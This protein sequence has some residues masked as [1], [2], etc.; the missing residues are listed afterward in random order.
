MKINERKQGVIMANEMEDINVLGA[1]E[2]AKADSLSD[3]EFGASANESTG[4]IG[5]DLL[6][7]VAKI[8][9]APQPK[10]PKK[11]DNSVLS[12]NPNETVINRKKG[13]E[14]ALWHD[15]TNAYKKGLNLVG[16]VESVEKL[17]SGITVV[18][19]SYRRQRI[20]IPIS[21]M[22]I[23]LT[24]T[25]KEDD[26]VR[27]AKLANSMLGAEIDFIIKGIDRATGTVIASRKEAMT[28]KRKEFYASFD[29]DNSVKIYPGKVVEARVIGVAEKRVRFEIFGVEVS[30]HAADLSWEW[31]ADARDDYFVGDR[32]LLNVSNVKYPEGKHDSTWLEGITVEAE[33][34]SLTPNYMQDNFDKIAEQGKYLG[35]VTD[36]H[37]ETYF[38]RLDTGV[39]AISHQVTGSAVPMKKDRVAFACTRKDTNTLVAIG[40]I[41]RVI[42]TRYGR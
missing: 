23:K 34:K 2:A 19:T 9:E 28:R 33:A 36:I 21:E 13:L 40:L 38:I 14:E 35:T 18:T 17:P 15:L 16:S 3:D 1:L 30:V 37:N 42:H 26:N 8:D 7:D 27:K 6:G 41:T 39:N 4:G 32:V 12:I 29:E 22:G 24:G 20:V 25:G 11:K 31:I 5:M 10:A